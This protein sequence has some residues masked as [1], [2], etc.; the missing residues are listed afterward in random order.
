[1]GPWGRGHRDCVSHA[2]WRTKRSVRA[3]KGVIRIMQSLGSQG[4]PDKH[5]RA[6]LWR[7]PDVNSSTV[8]GSSSEL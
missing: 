3:H 8:Q 4:H 5:V 6:G 7:G 2:P 1:M